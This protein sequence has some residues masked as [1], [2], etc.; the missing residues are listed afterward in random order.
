MSTFR[1]L[2][3]VSV[4]Y[5]TYQCTLAVQDNSAALKSRPAD[6]VPP[7]L[8]SVQPVPEALPEPDPGW[9]KRDFIDDA[10]GKPASEVSVRSVNTHAFPFP[11]QG[12]TSMWLTVRKH[13][14]WGREVYV[15][16]DRGQLVCGYSDC[17][18]IV[19]VHGKDARTATASRSGDSSS[20][21]LF[22]RGH[23]RFTKDLLKADRL[24]IAATFYQQGERAFEFNVKG[25][26]AP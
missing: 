26:Q 1:V 9:V 19:R 23:D 14:R 24:T 5:L 2:V 12:G 16:I 25:F 22:I 21:V 10:S 8:E 6:A 13:P 11:Y 20:T 18:V 3:L 17:N 7:L 15:S 4:L